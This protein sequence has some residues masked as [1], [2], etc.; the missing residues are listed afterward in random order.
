MDLAELLALPGIR[1]ECL[2]RSNIGFMALHGGSQDRGTE[3]IAEM[4]ADEAGASHYAIVQLLHGAS[5]SPRLCTIPTIRP[6]C[7][8]SLE[9]VDVA[10]SVHGFGRDGFALW[11]DPHRGLIVEPYGPA[12]RGKQTGPLRG[13]SWEA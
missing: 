7:G 12:L 1:E 6:I 5:T 2:L 9:H 4:V 11:L 10:I 3:Q 8:L 13:S